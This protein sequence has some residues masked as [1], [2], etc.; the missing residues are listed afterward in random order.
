VVI[1]SDKIVFYYSKQNVPL[2]IML[3]APWLKSK[4]LI[5]DYKACSPW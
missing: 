4:L 5:L 1:H 3:G 2:E